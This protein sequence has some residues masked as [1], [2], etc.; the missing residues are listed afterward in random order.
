MPAG[1]EGHQCI[2]LPRACNAVETVSGDLL[3]TSPPR[4]LPDIS[5]HMRTVA[6]GPYMKYERSNFLMIIMY[7]MCMDIICNILYCI[8]LYLYIY[9]ALLGVHT[10]PKR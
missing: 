4:H 3:R 10:N 1:K 9:I 5:T 6:R 2:A 7:F 8:V